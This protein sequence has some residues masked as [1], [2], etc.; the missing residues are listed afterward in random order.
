LR[1]LS[2]LHFGR[3][4]DPRAGG[5]P[6]HVDQLLG[7]L[8]PRL[9]IANLVASTDRHTRVS[10]RHGYALVEAGCHGLVGGT[11]VAPAM[12]PIAHRLVRQLD[13]RIVHLHLPDPLSLLIAETLS[14]S[15]PVVAT[16]H[17][18]V[19]RQKAALRLYQPLVDR[20]ARRMPA[21]IGA[22]RAH[23]DTST[24][25]AAL[26]AERR[27]VIPYGI[28]PASVDNADARALG[29]RL[30]ASIGPGPVVLG[31]GRQVYYKGFEVLID[32]MRV[33]PGAT[34][35]LCGQGPLTPALR[36][37]A[38]AH[39]LGDR[40]LFAGRTTD[41]ELAGW[42]HACDVF[43]MPS[44]EQAECFGLVQLEAMACGKPVVT[45]RLGNGVNEVH[46]DGVVGL[47]VPVRD[48][49]ALAGALSRLLA[50]PGLRASMGAAGRDRVAR[51]FSL[52][53]MRDATLALYE[54]VA[55][56]R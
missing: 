44:V 4:A 35:V 52:T 43:C 10:R 30:R 13:V 27:R 53:G 17:S 5:I 55:A 45:T 9:R 47:A 37:R 38:E 48:A 33:L 3:F 32:A 14:R 50:D 6:R 28:D 24:Q 42:Y 16:W 29:V 39:G 46:A 34:L 1:E 2:V 20:L 18:D 21:M 26:P 11:A 56:G 25:L 8:A 49:D 36:A 7:A 19:I 40:V 41:E 54:E 15:I 51:H 23:F 31:V 12:L 22:T